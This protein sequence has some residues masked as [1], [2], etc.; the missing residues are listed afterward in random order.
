MNFLRQLFCNLISNIE[1]KLRRWSR[2]EL[3]IIDTQGN[4]KKINGKEFR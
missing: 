2:D 3:Y 4:W 1:K